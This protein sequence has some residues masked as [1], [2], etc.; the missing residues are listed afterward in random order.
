MEEGA[1]VIFGT[2]RIVEET[3]AE[4]NKLLLLRRDAFVTPVHLRHGTSPGLGCERTPL[5]LHEWAVECRVVSDDHGSPGDESLDCGYVDRASAHHIV[6]DVRHGRDLGGNVPTRVPQFVEGIDDAVQMRPV[7]RR[8]LEQNHT[9]L[10]DLIHLRVE[11]CR[12]RIKDDAKLRRLAVRLGIPLH[13]LQLPNDTIVARLLQRLCHKFPAC[14]SSS[15][16]IASSPTHASPYN[17]VIPRFPLK[18]SH[19][20]RVV[21][22]WNPRAVTVQWCQRVLLSRSVTLHTVKR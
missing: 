11:P 22:V 17:I 7:R 12:L 21:T 19:V 1:A 9:Q 2:M 5:L 20:S 13:Q 4:G 3:Q 15:S 10:N 6:R 14:H 16:V 18:N 8:I